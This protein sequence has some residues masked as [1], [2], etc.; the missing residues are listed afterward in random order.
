MQAVKLY[1]QC[2]TLPQL[3]KVKMT[4]HSL[5]QTVISVFTT[6]L[7]KLATQYLLK[8]KDILS[9]RRALVRTKNWTVCA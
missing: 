5:R 4:F 6:V 2:G 1:F 3:K 8:M 7:R 9:F